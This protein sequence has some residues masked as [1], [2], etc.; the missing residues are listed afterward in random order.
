MGYIV[1]EGRF[2]A[3]GRLRRRGG[4]EEGRVGCYVWGSAC[5]YSAGGRG[6][7]FGPAGQKFETLEQEE[8][9][10]R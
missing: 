7:E 5:V 4:E 3:F 9:E 2:A 1:E 6:P 10:R 8:R